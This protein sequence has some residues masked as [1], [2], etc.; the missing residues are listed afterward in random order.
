MY[1][2]IALVDLSC[3]FKRT[4]EAN[5]NK[6]AENTLAEIVRINERVEHLI[7]CLDAP[8]YARKQVFP[9]YKAHREEPTTS[10]TY[11]KRWLYEQLEERGFQMAKLKGQEADDVIATLARIYGE[12]CPEV[13]LVGADKDLAQ[14][15]T[16][17][18]LQLIPPHG[19]RAE[20]FRGPKEVK[21]KYGVTP[22]QMPLWLALV[23]DKSDN[24]PGVKGIGQVKAATLIG[25]FKTLTGIAENLQSIPGQVGKAL[26]EGWEQL[27]LSSKLTTL[28]TRLPLD[29]QALLAKKEPKVP[30]TMAPRVELEF[31]GFMGNATP[32]PEPELP[33]VYV[34]PGQTV[35]ETAR[36]I[37]AEHVKHNDMLIGKDPRADEFLRQEAA[38]REQ[39]RNADR[40]AQEQQERAAAREQDRQPRREKVEF[41][42]ERPGFPQYGSPD[43]APKQ[44]PGPLE[45]ARVKERAAAA[46]APKATDAEFI[47][48]GEPKPAPAPP[49]PL[50]PAEASDR[51]GLVKTKPDPNYGLVTEDLQPKDLRS[52]EVISKWLLASNL[53]PQFTSA[54]AI[55]AVIARGKE[56][57][58]GMTTALA[59][60]HV[61]EGKPTASA[62]LIRA[63]AVR[64]KKCKYLRLVHSDTK[65][66][67]W[68]TWHVDHPEP[69][70]YTYTIE[71][72]EAAGLLRPSRNGKPSNWVTRPRD[73][74]TKTA[75]SKLCRVVYPEETLGLYC[76]EEMGDYVDTVGVAA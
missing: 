75:G 26:A 56:M 67:T 18:V 52:A 25:E 37:A 35:A 23:G 49:A 68:E 61:V 76:P 74:L 31:D 46:A 5:P 10:E 72:A 48:F 13:W 2:T 14:C 20:M 66:A 8:P 34:H 71:E 4:F 73:L 50:P 62:D 45:A 55:F 27:V 11:Q 51:P 9:D 16:D 59:G 57:G 38:A 54:A 21:E 29:A 47:P 22:D 15:V 40:A 19:E 43:W 12:S 69:T 44:G 24:I 58:I 65:S 33:T 7:L 64:S 28:D 60:F 36:Q 42:S 17:N 1:K 32:M 39:M 41:D 70:K 53:Y 30:E 6:G 63:L 3:L